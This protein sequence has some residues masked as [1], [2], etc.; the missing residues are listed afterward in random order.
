MP[1][2]INTSYAFKELK[3]GLRSWSRSRELE[4]ILGCGAGAG[5]SNFKN[6]GAGASHFENVGAK[7]E[8][9]IILP[10]LQSSFTLTN[11]C[12]S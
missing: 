1:F 4:K 2:L 10:A 3:P 9:L 8:L 6:A 11:K 5:A 12:K 7:L